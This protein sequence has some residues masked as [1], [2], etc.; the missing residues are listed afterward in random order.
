MYYS[1]SVTE[2]EPEEANSKEIELELPHSKIVPEFETVFEEDKTADRDAVRFI[3]DPMETAIDEFFNF[4]NPNPSDT[5]EID[6]DAPGRTKDPI[7]S[8]YKQTKFEK[9][10]MK[11]FG[12]KNDFYDK[13]DLYAD[14]ND[15]RGLPRW[16]FGEKNKGIYLDMRKEE[17]EEYEKERKEIAD[18]FGKRGKGQSSV[19]RR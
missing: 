17:E 8:I 1:Y 10:A 7:L 18:V 14:V 11:R 12:L 5:S 9:N 19:K 16:S 3:K 2:S 6:L 15:V 4:E 13:V